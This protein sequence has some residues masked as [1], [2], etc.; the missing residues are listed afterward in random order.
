MGTKLKDYL[1]VCIKGLPLKKYILP[2]FCYQLTVLLIQTKPCQ[3]VLYFFTATP[4]YER[5]PVPFLP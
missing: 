1:V 2:H 4:P 3:G 5:N